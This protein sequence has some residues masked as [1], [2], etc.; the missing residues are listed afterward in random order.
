MVKQR[1][2]SSILDRVW[3]AFGFCSQVDLGF[4]LSSGPLFISWET[5]SLVTFSEEG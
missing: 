5:S 2:N 4:N 1:G 3:G